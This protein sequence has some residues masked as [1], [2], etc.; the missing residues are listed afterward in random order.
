MKGW[1]E[2]TDFEVNNPAAAMS[3]KHEASRTI[4]LLLAAVASVSLIVGGISIMNIMLVSV[5]ERTREIGLRI[6]VGARRTDIQN[7][8]LIEATAL[9]LLG[10]AT[11][12][13]LGIAAAVTMGTISGWPIF[14]GPETITLAI[15]FAGAVGVFFGYYPASR[16][17]KLDPVEALRFE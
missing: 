13:V 7:Q 1:E 14:L 8:F 6:A 17:S 9:C 11:G 5:T 4:A 12:A 15:C 16:A 3:A 2:K 10:G